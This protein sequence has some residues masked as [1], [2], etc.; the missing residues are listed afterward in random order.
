LNARFGSIVTRQLRGS[1]FQIRNPFGELAS[2]AHAA[3]LVQ[4]VDDIPVFRSG[5]L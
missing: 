4:R 2:R 5:C 3:D 1:L